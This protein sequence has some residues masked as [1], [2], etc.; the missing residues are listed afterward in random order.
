MKGTYD[1]KF[2]IKVFLSL[3]PPLTLIF[4]V[5]GSILLGIATVNQAGAIGAVGATIM[6]GYRLHEGKKHA[7][8]PSIIAG[9]IFSCYF[10]SLLSSFDSNNKKY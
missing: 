2:A 8:T 4:V 3:V 1:R 7:Y 9:H 5:L 10:I 6:G